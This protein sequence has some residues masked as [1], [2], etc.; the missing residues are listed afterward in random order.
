MMN[1]V[2]Q[3]IERFCQS[4]DKVFFRNENAAYGI[5]YGGCLVVVQRSLFVDGGMTLVTLWT[6]RKQRGKGLATRVLSLL[7]KLSEETGVAVDS[8]VSNFE[9]PR[10]PN[11]NGS[12]DDYLHGR[13]ALSK[14]RDDSGEKARGMIK[15]LRK[16]G[17][18]TGYDFYPNESMFEKLHN[19]SLLDRLHVYVPKTFSHECE[20]SLEEKKVGNDGSLGLWSAI[21]NRYEYRGNGFYGVNLTEFAIG[22]CAKNFEFDFLR[23]RYVMGDNADE[24]LGQLVQIAASTNTGLTVSCP[25]WF[26]DKKVEFDNDR[27][28]TML[29][30]CGFE[31]GN[32]NAITGV[33]AEKS[34][35]Y[36]PPTFDPA[37]RKFIQAMNADVNNSGQ[38]GCNA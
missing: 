8:F 2:E 6:H 37:F 18:K 19:L 26:N 11:I 31:L 7:A 16:S 33:D 4:A 27:F 14:I 21:T 10:R 34:L 35:Y 15:L 12:I 22:A 29:V 24:V 30:G 25:V 3:F 36:L 13:K 23:L 38:T 28:E 20:K 1:P 32:C 9:L 5:F 17:F